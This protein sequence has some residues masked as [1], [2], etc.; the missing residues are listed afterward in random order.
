MRSAQKARAR[1]DTLHHECK[2]IE[3]THDIITRAD[4][5]A[6]F[7]G[8]PEIRVDARGVPDRDSRALGGGGGGSYGGAGDDDKGVSGS[9]SSS[10]SLNS[11]KS[12]FRLVP[13]IKR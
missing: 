1:Q 5:R 8:G 4:L 11:S 3:E 12:R 2:G 7:V 9:D 6:T 13:F 10:L